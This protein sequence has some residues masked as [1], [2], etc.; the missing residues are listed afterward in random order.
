MTD[1]RPMRPAAHGGTQAIEAAVHHGV[2]TLFTLSGAHIFPL[3]D[4]AVGGV[5]AIESG[6]P[7]PLRLVDVRHEQTAVF[8]AEATGKLT[9]VPGFA[10][11][12]A[13]PGV[14][15]AVSA[16]AGAWVNGSP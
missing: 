11:V 8:A 10:A 5:A 4:A 16:V 12:T 1:T 13:G 2:T 6:T 3:Y 7:G 14:T 9:R 15:N